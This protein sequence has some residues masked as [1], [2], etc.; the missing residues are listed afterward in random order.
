MVSWKT[1]GGGLAYR[2]DIGSG[3]RVVL[4]RLA[5][6]KGG[7]LLRILVKC[8]TKTYQSSRSSKQSPSTTQWQ[9][10]NMGSV[11]YGGIPYSSL[12]W[13]A[14]KRCLHQLGCEMACLT[15]L[16]RNMINGRAPYTRRWRSA[17]NMHVFC[18][19]ETMNQAIHKITRYFIR[20]SRSA[21]I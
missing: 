1:F 2:C 20:S 5:S 18:Y 9:W 12:W 17:G 4:L 8:C 21:L 16:T 11:K 3:C 13:P 15:T 6:K 10:T 19:H 7:D 14:C